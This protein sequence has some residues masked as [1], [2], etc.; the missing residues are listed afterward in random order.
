MLVF[1]MVIERPCAVG[2]GVAAGPLDK[3]EEMER[4]ERIWKLQ[5]SLLLAG[6]CSKTLGDFSA[7][8]QYQS[9]L[10]RSDPQKH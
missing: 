6:E 5:S 2:L 7:S 9:E 4:L 8:F 1:R 3:R 10:G